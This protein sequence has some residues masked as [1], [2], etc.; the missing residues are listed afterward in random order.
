MIYISDLQELVS[1]WQDRLDN[2]FYPLAYRD[3]VSECIY[4]L[5]NLI[6]KSIEEEIESEDTFWSQIEKMTGSS[7]DERAA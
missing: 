5:N 6:N 7:T 4:E 3:A 2:Y 1:V